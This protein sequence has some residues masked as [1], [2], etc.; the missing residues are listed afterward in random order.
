MAS[1]A[2]VDSRRVLYLVSDQK[3]LLAILIIG[4]VLSFS[5]PYFL[6]YYN[7]VNIFS[8]MSIEGVI[9]IG[10]A[11]LIIV[12]ELDLSVGSNMAFSTILAVTF[13]QYGVAVGVIA[14]IV[15][16]TVIGIINGILVTRLK[17]SSVA[18]TLGMMVALNGVVFALTQSR[19]VKGTNEDFLAI[20][21]PLFLN[22]SG[23]VIIFVVLVAVFHIILKR[24]YFGRS[25]YAVGGN[26]VASRLFGIRVDRVRV[27]CFTIAGIM[28]GV[29]GVLLAAKINVASGRLGVNTALIVITAVLLG[30]VSLSGGEGS[31]VK[32][33][34]GFL[35][36]AILNNAMVLLRLSSYIQDAIRGGILILILVIDAVNV[37]RAK[38]R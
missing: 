10:M 21:Q 15:G 4:V 8:F 27:A 18:T 17:L 38:Y 7:I 14:G 1:N 31:V 9:V 3:V 22:I 23:S 20:A 11:F 36:I 28:A 30:G 12:G 32:A 29:A 19:S 33:F 16:G 13:Q 25:V 24:T 6:T 5:S 26:S 2:R 34:L 35:L 37:E